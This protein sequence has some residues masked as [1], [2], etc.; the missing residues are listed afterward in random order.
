MRIPP[1]KTIN[2][3]QK[4]YKLALNTLKFPPRFNQR[5]KNKTQR[6]KVGLICISWFMN[7]CHQPLGPT[8]EA[9]HDCCQSHVFFFISYLSPSKPSSSLVNSLMC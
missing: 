3:S 9:M 8:L 5:I 4:K 7:H 6:Y 1:I 2:Y